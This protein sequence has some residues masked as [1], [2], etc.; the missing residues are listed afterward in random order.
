M[1]FETRQSIVE[2]IKKLTTLIAMMLA[3]IKVIT[4]ELK[5]IEVLI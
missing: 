4:F 2:M 1:R 3:T 5:F